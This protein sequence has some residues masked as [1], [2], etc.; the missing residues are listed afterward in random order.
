MDYYGSIPAPSV[1]EREQNAFRAVPQY[2]SLSKFRSFVVKAVAETPPGSWS[3]Y[4]VFAGPEITK[5]V[6]L[7]CHAYIELVQKKWGVLYTYAVCKRLARSLRA[8]VA[9][10]YAPG[11]LMY[12]VVAQ[13]TLVGRTNPISSN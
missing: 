10:S 2:H 13:R 8:R 12:N 4:H 3:G 1:D 7:Q 9:A 5:H 6:I 11:G